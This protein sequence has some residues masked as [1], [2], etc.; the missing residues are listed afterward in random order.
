M[1][2]D[3]VDPTCEAVHASGNGLFVFMAV[4]DVSMEV[5][6][7]RWEA[8]DSGLGTEEEVSADG[9]MGIRSEGGTI[10]RSACL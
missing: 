4:G 2:G 6:A 8:A 10:A 9:T 5:E 1:E 3:T 7:E